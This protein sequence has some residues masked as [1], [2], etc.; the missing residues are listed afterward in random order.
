[1]IRIRPIFLT[2]LTLWL[3]IVNTATSSALT[4]SFT[5][6]DRA[7]VN[8]NYS[9]TLQVPD[10]EASKTYDIKLMMKETGRENLSQIFVE[11]AWK[12]T[13][14]YL[15]GVYPGTTRFTL[16]PRQA[17]ENAEICAR[18]RATGSKSFTEYCQSIR[19]DPEVTSSL[20]QTT[21]PPP[22]V[23]PKPSPNTSSSQQKV[24]AEPAFVPLASPPPPPSALQAEEEPLKL[25]APSRY[26]AP[27]S[28]LYYS[29]AFMLLTTLIL[30]LLVLRKI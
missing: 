10:A 28:S 12:S 9:L 1:M 19:I 26:R 8:S 18:V 15:K 30:I 25:Q 14:Y 27:S 13:F 5:S 7:E 24:E 2:L 4:L 22:A 21:L 16:R 20:P 29:G 23:P 6:S 17:S 3:L 11:G